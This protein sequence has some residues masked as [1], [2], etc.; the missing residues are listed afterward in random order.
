MTALGIGIVGT[1]QRCMYFFGPYIK[2]HP[3]KARLV[4]LADHNQ[5]RLE[6]AVTALGGD[7]RS[8][9]SYRSRIPK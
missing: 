3:E 8:F 7:I 5:F 6:S 4:A 9:H 1:G 2:A